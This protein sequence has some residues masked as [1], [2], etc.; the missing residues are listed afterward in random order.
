M[1]TAIRAV[2]DFVEGPTVGGSRNLRVEVI[3]ELLT[4]PKTV[5][6]DLGVAPNALLTTAMREREIRE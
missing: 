5:L 3:V 6:P 1:D 4:D 2:V